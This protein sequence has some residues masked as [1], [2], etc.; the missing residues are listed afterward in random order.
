V[1]TGAT[2]LL[3]SHLVELLVENG[4]AVRALVRPG[5]DTRL[6]D[7]LGVDQCPGDLDDQSTLLPL[8]DGADI[9]FHCAAR[10][11]DW[12][13]WSLY[14]RQVVVATV[15]LLKA[16]EIAAVG[17]VLHVSSIN[18]YG[19]PRERAT[20]F[21]ESEPLGQ[22]LWWWDHYCRAK[23]RAEQRLQ[24]YPGDWTVVRPSWTYGPRD[25]NT[26]PRVLTALRSRRVPIVGSGK[27]Q[28]NI[29][30]ASDVAEGAYRA[31]THPDAVGQA[32][33]LASAGEITQEDLV[34][35]LTDELG[36]PRIR[37]HIPFTLA[38][39]AGFFSEAWG[40]LWKKEKPPNLTRYAVALLG[41]STRFSTEK[42]RT[43]LGWTPRV[44]IH[45]GLRRT[46]SWYRQQEGADT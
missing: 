11:G 18:V 6:L 45:D 16:C 17:R 22:D 1:V 23:V 4:E 3:G 41:R 21:T 27:N 5:S 31:A 42:A 39:W 25:R 29:V 20:P 36:L 30:Y 46:L 12:G 40:R 43:Q 38:F 13:P 35:T 14:H 34:N 9:V 8:V 15:N 32:Y 24:A 10:V 28:L 37:R 26:F 7:R 33:N 19:H 44:E 2:G